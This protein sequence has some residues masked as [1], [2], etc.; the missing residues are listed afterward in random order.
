MTSQARQ[1]L[2]TAQGSKLLCP[3][4]K[5]TFY[6]TGVRNRHV[7]DVH[8][9]PQTCPHPE[10]NTKLKGKRALKHHL[11]VHHKGVPPN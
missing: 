6:S 4:C 9:V 2:E 3:L 10:C 8:S 5:N 7:D 11:S 1:E